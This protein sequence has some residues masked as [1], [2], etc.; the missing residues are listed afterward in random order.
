MYA[1]SFADFQHHQNGDP[2]ALVLNIPS[3]AEG[4]IKVVDRLLWGCK[5]ATPQTPC[6]GYLKVPKVNNPNSKPVLED[7]KISIFTSY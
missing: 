3:L 5:T 1:R 2:P 7:F 6:P 4:C